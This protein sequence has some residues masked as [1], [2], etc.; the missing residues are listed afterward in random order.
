MEEKGE[1]QFLI[2]KYNDVKL[3]LLIDRLKIDKAF[4]EST[5]LYDLFNYL[6]SKSLKNE[7]VSEYSIA[8]D[9][10]G[11]NEDFDP[12]IDSGV[13]ANVSRLR[14]Y[15]DHYNLA[16]AEK[17]GFQIEFPRRSY[18]IKII[19]LKTSS[20]Q[21]IQPAPVKSTSPIGYFLIAGAIMLAA[22]AWFFNPFDKSSRDA[23]TVTSATP[24]YDTI[25]PKLYV[26]LDEDTLSPDDKIKA[27][28]F[29]R[30]LEGRFAAADLVHYSN[31]NDADFLLRT[32]FLED[33]IMLQ[34]MD[35]DGSIIH[36]RTYDRPAEENDR[37]LND[38][39]NNV[40]VDFA[41][42]RGFPIIDAQLSNPRLS[43]SQ[44]SNFK[45][46]HDLRSYTLTANFKNNA[47][48]YANF[49][50]LRACPDFESLEAPK[51]IATAHSLVGYLNVMD[52]LARRRGKPREGSD[53]KSD[54][55]Y[56]EDPLTSA[57]LSFENAKS[58]LPNLTMYLRQRQTFEQIRPDR[59]Q[60]EL[61][62]VMAVMIEHHPDDI[63]ILVNQAFS[64]GFYLNQWEQALALYRKALDDGPYEPI[65]NGVPRGKRSEEVI[66]LAAYIM[67]GDL[68]MANRAR[69]YTRLRPT[70]QW[71]M[72]DA[73]LYCSTGNDEAIDAIPDDVDRS[74]D[75]YLKTLEVLNYHPEVQSKF[76]S[77]TAP[78]PCR[79]FEP[80][81]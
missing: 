13:R 30:Y 40:A 7:P 16:K 51:D 52:Y 63:V 29:N 24:T 41:N 58:V 25:L 80:K 21:T 74:L 43:E 65:V 49:N 68:E 18:V 54:P 28:I 50:A 72:L 33:K 59:D 32:S 81:D 34:M 77:I 67:M 75:T 45:C 14:K 61:D 12:T 2:S 5:I 19:Q 69:E 9:V 53:D 4:G 57:A 44:L 47:G 20:G 39:T 36:S 1:N 62:R 66:P 46:I 48:T 17:N 42:Q 15:V 31:E 11:K 3:D 38:L 35:S 79:Y 78:E 60:E 76:R 56:V 23:E 37:S 27:S 26:T 70:Q 10:L 64:Y 71:L 73:L 6:L 55:H 22:T 8:L